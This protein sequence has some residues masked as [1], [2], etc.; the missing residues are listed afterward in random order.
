[1]TDLEYQTF[2]MVQ[3]N[4]EKEARRIRQVLAIETLR[5]FPPTPEMF[6]MAETNFIEAVKEY[7]NYVTGKN[8][9][10]CPLSEAKEAMEAARER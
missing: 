5:R 3:E 1:M 7:R 8:R 4:L 2:R 9:Q 10:I 6:V